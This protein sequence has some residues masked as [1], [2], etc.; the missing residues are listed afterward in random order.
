MV[1]MILFSSEIN[2]NP[3]IRKVELWQSQMGKENLPLADFRMI[4]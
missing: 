2:Y 3:F 4:Y 1:I